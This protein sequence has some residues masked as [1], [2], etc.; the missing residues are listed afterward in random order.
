MSVRLLPFDA[1]EY[2]DDDEAIAAYAE[3]VLEEEQTADLHRALDPVAR[4]LGFALMA[5][6]AGVTR[7]A[8]FEALRDQDSAADDL[9]RAVLVSAS[10]L[11][12]REAAE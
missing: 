3:A 7:E 5:R 2:L 6:M 10:G 9:F 11:Q 12:D 8:L 4:A 1:A